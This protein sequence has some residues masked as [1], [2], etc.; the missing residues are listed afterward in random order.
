MLL[1]LYYRIFEDDKAKII[2]QETLLVDTSD[3]KNLL[4]KVEFK[5]VLH[6]AI[7]D[8]QSIIANRLK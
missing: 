1:L 7:F 5:I 8:M 4:Q 6:G 2:L 3:V